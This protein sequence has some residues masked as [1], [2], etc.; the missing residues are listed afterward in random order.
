MA[1]ATCSGFTSFLEH[2]SSPRSGAAA[3]EPAAADGD[4]RSQDPV[5]RGPLACL[6][7][8]PQFLALLALIRDRSSGVWRPG[9]PSDVTEALELELDARAIDPTT[10]QRRDDRNRAA[11]ETTRALSTAAFVDRAR[12]GAPTVRL[13]RNPPRVKLGR[14]TRALLSLDASLE[15][16]RTALQS[17]TPKRLITAKKR[18]DLLVAREA[19]TPGRARS[20][21]G[22]RPPG[23]RAPAAAPKLVVEDQ[24][25]YRGK[26]ERRRA[27]QRELLATVKP[28]RFVQSI[29]YKACGLCMLH[30]PSTSFWISCS[31]DCIIRLLERFGLS[32]DDLDA[33]GANAAALCY[34][35]LPLCCFCSQFFDPD[36]EDGLA[37]S[38][39]PN[40]DATVYEPYFDS[41]YPETYTSTLGANHKPGS[42]IG[43]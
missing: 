29:E 35:R 5:G 10:T 18:F 37:K 24:Y 34:N 15:D 16:V 32:K 36:N 2:S 14:N 38:L 28:P 12:R 9:T 21:A 4:S 17:A 43:K 19:R 3:A 11:R 42:P 26:L 13:Q 8:W 39:N 22:A 25:D 7:G 40:R 20:A 30:F 31:H 23:L 27:N 33:R 1:A 6:V 41:E